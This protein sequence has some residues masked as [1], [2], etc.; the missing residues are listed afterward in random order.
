MGIRSNI[1]RRRLQRSTRRTT[2]IGGERAKYFNQGIQDKKRGGSHRYGYYSVVHNRS[3]LMN[4]WRA[5]DN[6]FYGRAIN[7]YF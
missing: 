4:L 6:G 2:N 3:K 5:Y 7:N 1:K